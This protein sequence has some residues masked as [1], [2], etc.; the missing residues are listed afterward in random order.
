MNSEN[1]LNNI[2][3]Q[4]KEAQIK[5]GY[6]K[7]TV[8]LYY[9]MESM[10]EI[11]GTAYESVPELLKSLQHEEAFSSGALGTITFSNHK[12]RIE[13]CIPPEGSEYVHT[14]IPEPAFLVDLIH[15]FQT[16]HHCHLEDIHAIF[17][18]FSASYI[19]EKMPEG[20]DFDFVFAF[21]DKAI[22]GYYY[23]IKEEMAHTIY[24]RFSPEDYKLLIE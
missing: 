22:D 15:L 13:V 14:E 19:F 3:D 18:K 1:L 21:V 9:P 8:R 2:I 10:Q 20:S 24:H 6:A 7:E 17:R 12:K 4:I 11:L 16:N 5:L 23:C